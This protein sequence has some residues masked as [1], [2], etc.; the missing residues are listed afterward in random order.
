MATEDNIAELKEEIPDIVPFDPTKKKKKKKVVIQDPADES[1]DKLAEKTENL[2]VIMEALKSAK[3]NL[4]VYLHPSQTKDVIQSVN[5]ELSS[6]LFK[7]NEIFDGVLL[8]HEVMDIPSRHGEILNGL[9]PYVGVRLTARL[10]LF[11]PKPDTY[12]EGKVV[13]VAQESI[14]VVVLGFSAAI[15][16]HEDIRDEFKFKIKSGEEIFRSSSHKRHIIKVGTMVRFLVK[17][18]DEEILHISGSLIPPSTGSIHWHASLTNSSR[19]RRENE[20]IK[21]LSTGTIDGVAISN[22]YHVLKKS[23]KQRVH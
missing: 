1:V 22:D 21:E 20:G 7:F 16:T 23:K 13:K 11:A 2:S 10:L 15:I 19:K 18:F 3:A 6:L 5:R 14:H 12:L 9:F 4:S 8:A 17:S